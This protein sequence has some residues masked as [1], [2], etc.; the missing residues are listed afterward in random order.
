MQN[1][2]ELINDEGYDLEVRLIDEEDLGMAKYQV[3]WYNPV[4]GGQY[5][6]VIAPRSQQ[7]ELVSKSFSFATAISAV[8]DSAMSVSLIE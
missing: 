7:A 2:G 4:V 8:S 1:Q 6:F 5:R 3:R